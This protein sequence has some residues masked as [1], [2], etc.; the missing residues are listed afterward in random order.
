MIKLAIYGKGGIGKS[1]C[2]ANLAA[3]FAVLGKRVIQI[4]CDPKAD[5]TMNLLGGTPV[6]PV[7][8]HLREHDEEPEDPEEISKVGFGGVL[9][10]ETGGPT[11]GLGCAGRGIITTFSL[12]EELELFERFKPD[13]V[14]YDVLGD[15]VCGGFAAP[16]REGYASRVLIV[17]SGEKMALYA[18]NNINSA[19]N[20]FEDRGYARVRGVILNRRNV[21]NEE[22][23]V[24]AFTEK[25]GLEIAADIP[26]SQ[27]II[28]CEDKGMTVIEGAP[29]SDAAKEFFALAKMLIEEDEDHE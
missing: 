6:T 14:L 15:V 13:V 19:V 24:R 22:E 9:C 7:M 5:S 28:R 23:K 4:G 2:T 21:E 16:I 17:T 20:N 26:R 1:T 27:D 3:A 18:A 25:A 10:I 8:D 29:E 12:L 11:P